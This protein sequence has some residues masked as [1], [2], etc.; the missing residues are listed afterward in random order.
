MNTKGEWTT[1]SHRLLRELMKEMKKQ[2]EH[3]Y[4]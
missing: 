1:G 3:N 2:E 4:A